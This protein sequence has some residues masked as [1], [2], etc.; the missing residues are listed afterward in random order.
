[1]SLGLGI[2][3]RVESYCIFTEDDLRTPASP[4]R[5]FTSFD[6]VSG[7]VELV[8]SHFSQSLAWQLPKHGFKVAAGN[9]AVFPRSHLVEDHHNLV[10]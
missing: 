3:C 1:V 5:T 4:S 7:P 6:E 9:G 8:V 2:R 10:G